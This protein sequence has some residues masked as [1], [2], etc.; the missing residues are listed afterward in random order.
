M[1]NLN[2]AQIIRDQF[3]PFAFTCECKGAD[4]DCQD[5]LQNPYMCGVMDTVTRIA[6]Y[7]DKVISGAEMSDPYAKVDL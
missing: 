7:L 6:N 3:T 2:L 4:Y 1:T 5:V